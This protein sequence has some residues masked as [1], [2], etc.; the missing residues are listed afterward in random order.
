M[1]SIMMFLVWDSDPVIRALRLD[2]IERRGHNRL[3]LTSIGSDVPDL[4]EMKS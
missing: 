1:G 4:K 3:P 2:R